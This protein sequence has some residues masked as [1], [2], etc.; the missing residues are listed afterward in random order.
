L[1]EAIYFKAEAIYFKALKMLGLKPSEVDEMDETVLNALFSM[2]D[3]LLEK[4]K[5]DAEL[6]RRG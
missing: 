4:Q 2:N 6:N 1:T 3:F 5:R